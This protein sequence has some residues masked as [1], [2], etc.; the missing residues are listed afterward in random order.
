MNNS[1]GPSLPWVFVYFLSGL[2]GVIMLTS[3]FNF[4][5]L[6]IARS[7]TRAREIGV[8]KVTGAARWQIF[9]QFLS[10]SIVVALCALIAAFGLLL[11]VKPLMLQLTFAKIFMWDLQ[12]NYIV[13]G[14]FIVFAIT[15]GILAGFFPAVVLSGFQP[16]KV[17]KNM[18]NVKL[19]SRIGMRKALLIFQ[20]TLSLMFILTVIVMYKQLNLFMKKDHGF[21]MENKIMIRLNSTS[22]QA[23]KTELQKH[24]NVDVVTGV[25]HVPAAG[26]SYGDGFKKNL[27][28]KDWT[29]LSYFVVDEDYIKNMDI[30]MVTGEF[31]GQNIESNKNLVIINE[32]AVKAFKYETAHDAIGEEIIYQADFSRKTSVAVVKNYNHE[33]LMSKIEPM[34]LL[35]NPKEFNI[36]QVKYTGNF[37]DATKSIENSWAAVNPGLKIDFKDFEAEIK[38]FYNTIFGDVVNIV[39]VIAGLAIMISCLGLL[40]MATYTTETRVKEISIRKVLGST[41]GA[42][43]YLLSKSFLAIIGIAIVIAVPASYFLNTLWLELIPYHINVDLS[44]IALGVFLLIVFALLTIGSQTWRATFVNPV[45]NLKNE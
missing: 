20:F 18:N 32:A 15:V 42:L 9:L 24:S 38:S 40:G 23:L 12:A 14:I 27:A 21:S 3:C 30:T 35:Y 22:Y 19:F 29:N 17:L 1:I 39:G 16:I 25:S 11:L 6:S 28:E 4:T 2:A 26:T 5:N 13:F 34:A 43:V 8:R 10:E 33:F 37:K 41:N 31:F 45:E 44:S 7:L 36:L